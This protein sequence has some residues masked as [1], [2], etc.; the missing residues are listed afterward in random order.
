M[1]QITCQQTKT[2]SERVVFDGDLN[3]KQTL[4][5]GKTL[6]LLDENAGLASFKVVRG[7]VATAGYDHLNFWR[8][9]TTDKYMRIESVVTGIKG[10]Q[11]EVF[12]KVI[13][14]DLKTNIKEIAFTG[15]CTM[16]VL[17]SATQIELPT[18]VPETEEEKY[19]CAGFEERLQSRQAY[20]TQKDQFLGHLELD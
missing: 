20:L 18:L 16:V 6:C 5:G 9:I 4:F 2:I 8:P 7:K 1:K 12:T 3:D 11:V 15:F 13:S 19:L 17:R 14:H 10:R